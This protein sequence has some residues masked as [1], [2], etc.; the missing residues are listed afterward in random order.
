MSGRTLIDLMKVALGSLASSG[1]LDIYARLLE[2][3]VIFKKMCNDSVR[4]K[5]KK[6]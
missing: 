4:N 2:K 3:T 6:S 5:N 1:H